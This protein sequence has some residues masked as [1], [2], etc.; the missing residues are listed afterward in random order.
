M[1]RTAAI[2]QDFAE[3]VVSGFRKTQDLA[4][5]GAT[6]WNASLKKATD[7][8]GGALQ[9]VV[10]LL[11]DPKEAMDVVFDLTKTVVDTQLNLGRTVAGRVAGTAAAN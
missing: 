9:S 1:S 11:P 8:P 6:E 5:N 10:A 3:T 7:L 2:T 4:F